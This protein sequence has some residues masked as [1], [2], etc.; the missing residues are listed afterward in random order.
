MNINFKFHIYYTCHICKCIKHA[1][2]VFFI[3]NLNCLILNTTI[4]LVYKTTISKCSNYRR[5]IIISNWWLYYGD[6]VSQRHC[7]IQQYWF[8]LVIFENYICTWTVDDL[9]IDICVRTNWLWTHFDCL[10]SL[11]LYIQSITGPWF[12]WFGISMHDTKIVVLTCFRILRPYNETKCKCA[13]ES[14]CSLYY[15][16]IGVACQYHFFIAQLQILYHLYMF[17]H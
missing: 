7:W 15:K 1:L 5:N 17:Y 11:P 8:C 4:E 14:Q 3:N 13:L 9:T 10:L 2:N 12:T 6:Y 16:L